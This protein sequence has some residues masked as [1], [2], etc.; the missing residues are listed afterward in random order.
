M[1]LQLVKFALKSRCVFFCLHLLSDWLFND[2]VSNQQ[3]KFKW[4]NADKFGY[5]SGLIRFDSHYF[6]SIAEFGYG[7]EFQLAFFPLFPFVVGIIS[8]FV[9]LFVPLSLH[10]LILLAGHIVNL[11]AF[12]LA[13]CCLYELSMNMYQGRNNSEWN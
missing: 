4:E 9:H 8:R 7:E 1:K 2:L 10:V 5:F 6:M 12:I 13:T 11:I 3:E